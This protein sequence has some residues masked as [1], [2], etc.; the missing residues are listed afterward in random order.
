MV[1]ETDLLHAYAMSVSS[2]FMERLMIS[3]YSISGVLLKEFILCLVL[4][5]LELICIL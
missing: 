1:M 3:I 5:G 2:P 4:K